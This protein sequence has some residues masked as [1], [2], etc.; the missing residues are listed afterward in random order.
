MD[1]FGGFSFAEVSVPYI[2]W[3]DRACV[4]LTE[5]AKRRCGLVRARLLLFLDE[6]TRSP[7]LC[8]KTGGNCSVVDWNMGFISS[9]YHLGHMFHSITHP[10]SFFLRLR[11]LV[12]RSRR[13]SV[14][15]SGA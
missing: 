15:S 14:T 9:V 13:R 1:L 6:A 5:G 12:V 8:N 2:N 7:S 4:L 3:H 11:C 10:L